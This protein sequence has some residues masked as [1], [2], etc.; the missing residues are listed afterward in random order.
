M[1]NRPMTILYLV[2]IVLLPIVIAAIAYLV[3]TSTPA[4][5][6]PVRISDPAYTRT[7]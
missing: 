6:V 7:R 5:Q 3:L 4:P 2:P 1:T